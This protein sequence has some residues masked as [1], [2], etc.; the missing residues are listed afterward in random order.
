MGSGREMVEELP[1]YLARTLGKGP[2]EYRGGATSKTETSFV[3]PLSE[4]D[5]EGV[6]AAI[7][8][9]YE[10]VGWTARDGRNADLTMVRE[11]GLLRATVTT[12]ACVSGEIP[13]DGNKAR[14]SVIQLR[15]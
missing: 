13:Q 14:V 3:F 15:Y 11:G 9:Y 2:D 7:R 8:T 1:R 10:G 12:D 6:L 4:G 5:R